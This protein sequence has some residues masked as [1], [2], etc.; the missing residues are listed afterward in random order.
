MSKRNNIGEV[1][2]LTDPITIID[3]TDPITIIDL[4]EEI[5]PVPQTAKREEANSRKPSIFKELTLEAYERM[6]HDKPVV[7]AKPNNELK[8]PRYELNKPTNI[9]ITEKQYWQMRM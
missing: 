8:K 1:I 7:V 9:N 5:P 2:D 6:R 4:T 3:L